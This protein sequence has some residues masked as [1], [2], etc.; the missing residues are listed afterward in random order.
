MKIALLIIAIIELP[1]IFMLVFRHKQMKKLSQKSS[2]KTIGTISN[3]LTKEYADGYVWDKIEV[4][5]EV[6]GKCYC[7]KEIMKTT[8]YEKGQ[9]INVFYLQSNPKFSRVSEDEFYLYKPQELVVCSIFLAIMNIL[10]ISSVSDSIKGDLIFNA[11]CFLG[12]SGWIL[13][14]Y[15]EELSFQKLAACV[16]GRV[17]S[18]NKFKKQQRVVA[19][20]AVDGKT[21]LTRVMKIPEKHSDRFL[22]VGDSVDIRYSEKQ[23]YR[24]IVSGDVYMFANAKKGL[25]YLIPLII[26]VIALCIL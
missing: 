12:I 2:F 25:F 11:L 21:Y 10:I 6:N 8:G 17:V 1:L 24:A 4:E 15:F 14:N 3:V 19:E 22:N 23:P 13:G 26:I 9:Q 7:N 18:V 20:Y 16:K 5:Y